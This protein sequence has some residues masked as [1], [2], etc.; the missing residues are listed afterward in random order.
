MQLD[1]GFGEEVIPSLAPSGLPH[2]SSD[3]RSKYPWLQQGKRRNGQARNPEQP[4]EGF[5]GYPAVVIEIER[6]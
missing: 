3:A 5:P 1:I 6:S 4:H 2:D